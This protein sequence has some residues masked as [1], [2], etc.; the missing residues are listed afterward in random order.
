LFFEICRALW[1]NQF[2][3]MTLSSGSQLGHYQILSPLGKGGMGEV[4]RAK[5][6]RLGR[7]VA[8]KVL[9][10]RFSD[11]KN[12]L[13]RF[14]REGKA[15]AS[16][17]HPNILSIF[18]FGTEEGTSYA[19]MEIL[20]G[21]TLRSLLSHSTFSW[22]KAVGITIPIVEGLAAAHSKGITHRDLKPENVFV[23]ADGQIKILDFGLARQE[24]AVSEEQRSEAGTI[25][26]LTEPGIAVG[27]VPYMSPEQV[28]GDAVDARSDI[29]SF[30]C[31]LYEMIAGQRPFAGNSAADTSAAILK[32]D[33]QKIT[34]LG[35]TI[36]VELER[37][38]LRCLEKHPDQRVQS[39]RDLAYDLKNILGNS[40][41]TKTLPV[42]SAR[43]RSALLV[44]VII[45]TLLLAGS[46][47]W[48][49]G[50]YMEPPSRAKSI[51]V[52]PF[53]SM[54][55]DKESEYFCDGMTEDILTQLSKIGDLKVISS[56]LGD[57][58]QKHQQE[59][60][61]NWERIE[62]INCIGR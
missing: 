22:K 38:I 41:A 47:W 57:A 4:Y 7:E 50:K 49:R 59:P 23:T 53:R 26:R 39:A 34:E 16:L 35:K 32:D 37:I 55:S 17:A 54:S 14:E 21:E 11:D 5:D 28:R 24:R 56:N 44:L 60:E 61:G 36:P 48:Y 46:I 30:G 27:T 20:D 52:L 33:P 18:D 40:T 8:I 29:F 3:K 15:L 25:S 43:S 51:A 19:V 12:S 1:S 58:V 42:S 6:L 2:T 45:L 9:S 10:D 13:S 31:V 62:C